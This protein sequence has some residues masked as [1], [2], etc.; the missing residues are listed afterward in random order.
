MGSVMVCNSLSGCAVY[1]L[2]PLEDKNHAS[3][4]E[5]IP[6]EDYDNGVRS[7]GSDCQEDRGRS[8]KACPTFTVF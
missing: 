8:E 1:F 6:R 3:F 5:S 2:S 7:G 4:I